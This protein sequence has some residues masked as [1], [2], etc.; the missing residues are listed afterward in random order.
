MIHIRLEQRAKTPAW[1]NLALPL[2]AVLAT[3]LIQTAGHGVF[4]LNY[5]KFLGRGETRQAFLTRNVSGFPGVPWINA[6]LKKTDKV[7]IHQRQLR[8]Y[9]SVPSFFGSPMQATVNLDPK[10]TNARTLYRQLR[11]A[12][13]THFLLPRSAKAQPGYPPP[14]NILDRK[15]CL[16]LLKRFEARRIYSRTLSRLASNRQFLDILKLKDQSCL[17]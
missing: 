12:G 13:I 5:L 8:Y 15:G 11:Q 14:L 10:T 1:F 3:L 9:L 2:A 4:A 16:K 6:N 17:G 7:Y